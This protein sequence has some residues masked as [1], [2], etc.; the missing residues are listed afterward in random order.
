MT[1]GE[2]RLNLNKWSTMPDDTTIH[3]INWPNMTRQ[4][5]AQFLIN[6]AAGY[7]DNKPMPDLIA[8]HTWREVNGKRAPEA[9]T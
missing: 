8:R 9:T 6:Y 1:A 3:S 5:A 2:V 4:Q 7:E